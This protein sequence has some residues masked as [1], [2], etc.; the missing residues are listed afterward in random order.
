MSRRIDIELTSKSGDGSWTWRA[1]GARQPKGVVDAALVPADEAVGAVLRAEVEIGLDGIEVLALSSV[2]PVRSEEKTDGRIEVVGTPKRA[3]DVSV[4]LA[5]GGRRVAGVATTLT[6]AKR[7]STA[8][9]RGI[10]RTAR[11]RVVRAQAV[12]AVPVARQ[13]TVRVAERLDVSVLAPVPAVGVPE[14]RAAVAVAVAGRVV[15]VVHAGP[16]IGAPVRTDGPLVANDRWH[17]PRPCTAT[18]C[19]PR[20]VRNRFQ[21]QSSFSVVACPPYARPLRRRTR[22][23]GPR[24]SPRRRLTPCWP[25]PMSFSR[26]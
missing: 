17:R 2:K 26:W 10:A 13:V 14:A 19:W 18:P 1:A 24:G 23:L 4:I 22:P 25:W 9:T 16:G 5:P 12:P 15:A 20:C 11:A 8:R 3:P 6:T 7:T 21:W